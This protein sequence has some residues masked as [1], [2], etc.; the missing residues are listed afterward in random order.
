MAIGAAVHLLDVGGIPAPDAKGLETLLQ[1]I[2]EK[3]RSDDELLAESMRIL[4]AEMRSA[5]LAR[6][7]E[8]AA[9]LPVLLAIPLALFIL[10]SLM[11]V[12][13]TPVALRLADT[14]KNNFG[15]I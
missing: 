1:G 6:I 2:K 7:E 4:A 12:I 11:V 8:R 14:L 3:A 10:P 5:R 15:A 9:R 13:S